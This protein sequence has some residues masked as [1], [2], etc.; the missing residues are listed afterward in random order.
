MVRLQQK[1]KDQ[2]HT[3]SEHNQQYAQESIHRRAGVLRFS[4]DGAILAINKTG[5][6]LIGYAENEIAALQ[7]H[8]LFLNPTD[9]C[10][11]KS[12]L[13]IDGALRDQSVRLKTK[14]GTIIDCL[15]TARRRMADNGT[16]PVYDCV[17]RKASKEAYIEDMLHFV[18]Q[19]GWQQPGH[20]FFETLVRYLCEVLQVKYALIEE[21]ID[22]KAETARAVALYANGK[23]MEDIE[24]SLK[25]NL[26]QN[27]AGKDMC[28]FPRRLQQ[29]FHLDR[30]S[31][32]IEAE[33]YAG[34]PLWDSKGQQIGL[35]AVFDPKPFTNPKLVEALL[36]I[37]AVR[38]AHQL[39]Q[40]RNERTISSLKAI[41]EQKKIIA[42]GVADAVVVTDDDTNIL[43]V[44]PAW[45]ELTGYTVAESLGQTPHIISSHKTPAETYHQ[46]WAL[47]RK[48]K[49]WRGVVHNVRKDGSL[50]DADLTISPFNDEDQTLYVGVL[51][52]VTKQ[53]QATEMKEQFIANVVHDLGNPLSVLRTGIHLIKKNPTKLGDRLG[54]LESQVERMIQLTQDLLMLSR[55]DR[56]LHATGSECLDLNMLTAQVVETQS[57]LA[58]EKNLDI[59]FTPAAKPV[60]IYGV[61]RYLERVIVNLVANAISYMQR[62]TI[63]LETN[64]IENVAVLTIRDTGKGIDAQDLPC[65]FDRFYRTDTVRSSSEG[66]GLGLSIVREIVNQ[67]HGK[68]EVE[69]TPGQGTEF[70]VYFPIDDNENKQH[71]TEKQE[72]F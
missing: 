56:G 34:M 12:F 15:M 69:S 41:S 43:Y 8:T 54:V 16:A 29:L 46:M 33:S 38:T 47:V 44:N 10:S 66:T 20:D 37:A 53:Q 2:K 55:L 5:L 19:R 48:G 62:G 17:I 65:I 72:T 51:H 42:D 67:H 59:S 9:F 7:A 32:D 39:E 1:H 52:D 71:A 21:V 60:F 6:N 26:R 35:I 36:Q 68:I 30:E 11:V 49:I 22:S 14:Y 25:N 31:A 18:A 58:R 61:E 63:M 70:R 4:Q 57:S 50:F 13:E 28:R 45:E 3:Q 24:Y 27:G 40:Y 23:T 64:Q